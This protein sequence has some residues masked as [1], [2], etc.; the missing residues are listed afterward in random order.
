MKLVIRDQNAFLVAIIQ[1]NNFHDQEFLPE[2]LM[3]FLSYL[4]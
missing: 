1:I 4:S 2:N 3:V